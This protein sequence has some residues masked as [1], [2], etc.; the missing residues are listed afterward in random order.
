MTK[1]HKVGGYFSIKVVHEGFLC[2]AHI[3]YQ[4]TIFT[5]LIIIMIFDNINF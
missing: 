3:L 4:N 1:R 5:L 2:H